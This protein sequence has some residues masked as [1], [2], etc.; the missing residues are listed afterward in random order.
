MNLFTVTSIYRLRQ[1]YHSKDTTR[2]RKLLTFLHI[3]AFSLKQLPEFEDLFLELS[4]E[5]S[6]RI[7]ID[8]GF[9]DNLLSSVGVSVTE[10]FDVIWVHE[11][12]FTIWNITASVKTMNNIG[13]SKPP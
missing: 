12:F 3:N 11:F 5:F 7:F 10:M 1:T 6:I 4:Y 9:A 13:S 8:H 2:Y